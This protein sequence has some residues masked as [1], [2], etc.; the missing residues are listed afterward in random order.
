MGKV[1]LEHCD[2]ALTDIIELSD[3][4]R[5]ILLFLK[6]MCTRQATRQIPTA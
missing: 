1:C 3:Y 5:I 6:V 2:S 4:K